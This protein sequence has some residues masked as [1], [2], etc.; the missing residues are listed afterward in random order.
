MSTFN[1]HTNGKYIKNKQENLKVL[2]MDHDCS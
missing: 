1:D 2:V